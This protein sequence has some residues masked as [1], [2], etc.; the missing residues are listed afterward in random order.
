MSHATLDPRAGF[1][2]RLATLATTGVLMLACPRA[3]AAATLNCSAG[4]TT[5]L[6]A[7]IT[8]AN[9]TTEADTITLDDSSY[10]LTAVNNTTDGAT[11]LPA[12]TSP[13]TI[14]GR[15]ATHTFITRDDTSP[16]QFRI[17]LVQPD[18]KLQ[19]QGVTIQF[20]GTGLRGRD[21]FDPATSFTGKGGGIF[22]KYGTVILTDT[23]LAQNGT[24]H[25]GGG[26]ANFGFGSSVTAIRTTISR[27]FARGGGGG[28]CSSVGTV[29]LTNTTID[30]NNAY[31]AGGIVIGHGLEPA[32]HAQS[33]LI[34]TNSTI[35]ENQGS[36]DLA[37]PELPA[38]YRSVGA[39]A[40]YGG[41][42]S[43][44][45]L[46]DTIL[47]TNSTIS[48]NHLGPGESESRGIFA[49]ENCEIVLFNTIVAGNS[50][51]LTAECWATVDGKITSFGNNFLPAEGCFSTDRGNVPLFPTDR[52]SDDPALGPFA[53]SGTPGQGYLP[54][55]ADSKAINAGN[56]TFC[57]PLDQRGK[58]RVGI[59]DI[60]AVEFQP[61][62]VLQAPDL[63]E[64]YVSPPANQP[65]LVVTGGGSVVV[66][67]YVKNS[68]TTTAGS[69]TTQFYLSLNNV[70]DS[71]D[72][73]L[74]GRAVTALAPGV[75]LS[76]NTS[77]T[78]PPTTPTGTYFVLA[79]AD[80][81]NTVD[82]SNETNNCLASGSLIVV[83]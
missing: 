74:G 45:E 72:V 68:G 21:T 47:L 82:E 76:A 25:C 70:K 38:H 16:A 55:R 22:N 18:G 69:S 54:L 30:H 57:P 20:G 5:C 42:L 44:P 28:L 4:N 41:D 10:V 80:N 31:G 6:I 1:L 15:G 23:V 77:V 64:T 79:C 40:C 9:S 33:K 60:G 66:Q 13:I 63:I 26:I 12:I 73:L 53:N 67:D 17:F 71:G 48:K 8:S 78:V 61:G 51:G 27:N 52:K 56:S 39:L 3:G 24:Y 34:L 43:V 37:Y 7:A 59:C 81:T 50:G 83:K 14:I 35:A 2:G 36:H 46:K 19:L 29:T 11:G 62:E 65:S 58:A 32:T 75:S 49:Q